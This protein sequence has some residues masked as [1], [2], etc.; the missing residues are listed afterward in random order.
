M[1]IEFDLTAEQR[2]ARNGDRE[3]L[4]FAELTSAARRPRGLAELL[5]R[6]RHRT[7]VVHEDGLPKS[8]KQAAAALLAGLVR[9]RERRLS[10]DGGPKPITAPGL[11]AHG[12]VELGRAAPRELRDSIRLRRDAARDCEVPRS[13]PRRT[14]GPRPERVLYVRGNPT[15]TWKGHAVG[16]AATHMTGVV[17]GMI[18]NGVDVDVLAPGGLP[19]LRGRLHEVPVRRIFHFEPWLTMA[20]YAEEVRRA[21]AGI[22]GEAVYQ[23]YEPGSLA[24]VRIAADRDVPLILEYNG[25]ELWVE[26]NWTATGRPSRGFELQERI[27]QR[28]LE[29]AS[30]IVVVSEPLRDQLLGRGI[31]GERILVNPNGVDTDA[32][33]P[34][35]VGPA[36]E[37]RASTS[38]PEAP[39]VGFIGTFGFWHGVLELPEM[40]AR[41]TESEPGVR[42]VLVGDGQHWDDVRADLDRRGLLERVSMPGALPRE[43]ALRMLAAADVCVSPHVPNPDGSRF[44]GSPTKLFEYMGLGKPIV[45]SDLEQIGEVLDDG[46]TGLLHEPG[47][48]EAASRAVARLLSDPELRS[49]LGAAAL[50]RAEDRYTWRAHAARILEAAGS[51]AAIPA[52]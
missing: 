24:G 47:D 23:R 12:A 14:A 33:A 11:L 52:R 22:D 17:N 49:R 9:A 45:A 25:S 20:A 30:L 32:L 44:F 16:G 1:P 39:T 48:S 8:A 42:W 28:T 19:G 6:R 21:A 46:E 40:I 50:E 5:W 13:L 2:V 35:R 36:A 37:W 26:R 7:L 51:A 27:E 38:L 3:V 29:Q 15:M 4:G 34:Y 43:Q 10:V 18:D 41:V 31:D